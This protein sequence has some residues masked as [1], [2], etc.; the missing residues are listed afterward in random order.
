[1]VFGFQFLD[2]GAH[3]C[4]MYTLCNRYRNW[5]SETTVYATSPDAAFAD[6]EQ[7]V[8]S[9]DCSKIKGIP[10]HGFE[11]NSEGNFLLH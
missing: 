4:R 9:L 8:L 10:Y 5:T 7:A 6:V 2:S 11:F 3:D 1:M